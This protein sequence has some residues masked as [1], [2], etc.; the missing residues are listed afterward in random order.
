MRHIEQSRLQANDLPGRLF[1][2]YLSVLPGRANKYNS[3]AIQIDIAGSF[4]KPMGLLA[5]KR[6]LRYLAISL[7]F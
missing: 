2:E 1:H 5:R 6:A 4:K 3:V 7:L